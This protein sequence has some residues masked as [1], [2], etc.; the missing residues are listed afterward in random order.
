MLD[1]ILEIFQ[2]DEEGY[3]AL[4]ASAGKD[5]ALKALGEALARGD[6]REAFEQAHML[7]GVLGNLGLTPLYSTAC[8]IVEPLRHDSLEGVAPLYAELMQG[9]ARLNEIVGA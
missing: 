6:T 1:D 4:V 2:G 7:K 9:V 8:A 3:L 5:A